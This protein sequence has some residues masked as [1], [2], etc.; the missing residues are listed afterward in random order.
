M[1]L[2][3]LTYA[4]RRER[5]ALLAAAAAGWVS[6]GLVSQYSR[7]IEPAT[8]E[9]L[10]VGEIGG[11]DD[12]EF[13]R[14]RLPASAER[15]LL[16]AIAYHTAGD[17]TEAERRYRNLPQF[18]VSWN[19]LGVVLSRTR[20]ADEAQQAFGRALEIAPDLAEA[21]LNTDGLPRSLETELHQKY[22][23][24][25]KMIAVPD[26][27]VVL[28]A[29]LDRDWTGRYRLALWGPLRDLRRGPVDLRPAR[30]AA[31]PALR[32]I[33]LLIALGAA[34]LAIV[35]RRP[36]PSAAA[37]PFDYVAPGLS[38][39][40]NWA[41]GPVLVLWCLLVTMLVLDAAL[42]SPYVTT[43][44][45]QPDL[46]GTFGLLPASAAGLEGID[47]PSATIGAFALLLWLANWAVV[48]RARR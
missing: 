1:P 3:A 41:A 5:G 31:I 47:A 40:W 7:A 18:A 28:R 46:V 11:P 4:S 25:R 44:R 29:F 38:P 27:E 32:P 34:V 6:I 30:V 22:A 10:H 36:A 12:I 26:R 39:S 20:R 42:G 2:A 45:L 33:V 21:I 16:V 24:V 13:F 35:P 17:L 14:D 48:R 43:W 19:N 8:P 37:T 23:P 15:D 9:P